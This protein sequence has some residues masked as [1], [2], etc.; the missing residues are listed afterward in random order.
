MPWGSVSDFDTYAGFRCSKK[1]EKHWPRPY[2]ESTE[3]HHANKN[4]YIHHMRAGSSPLRLRNLDPY[5]SRLET[6][7]LLSHTVSAADTSHQMVRFRIQQWSLTPD[8]SFGCF[9]HRSQ[10]KTRTVWSC[11]QTQRGRSSKPDLSDLLR[12]P[13]RCPAISWLETR[14]WSTSHYLDPSDLPG[15]LSLIHISEPTRPY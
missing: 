1:V 13:R 5:T 9:F 14:L 8:R 2:L 6:I 7:G 12:S 10:L 3:S 15:H 11:C 4:S